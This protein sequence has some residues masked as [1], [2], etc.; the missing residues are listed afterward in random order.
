MMK[1]KD[2]LVKTT[3]EAERAQ[4][5][6]QS[7]SKPS[8]PAS[9]RERALEKERDDYMV[10]LDSRSVEFAKLSL[11]STGIVEVL[12]MSTTVAEYGNHKM[13]AQ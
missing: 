13:H 6:A 4:Q 8:G 1:L 10:C 2:Q 9:E 11:H 12:D 5:K 7:L 3:K